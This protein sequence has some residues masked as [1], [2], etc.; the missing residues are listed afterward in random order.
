L[1]IFNIIKLI[2]LNPENIE[3]LTAQNYKF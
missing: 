1:Y 3:D 2:V